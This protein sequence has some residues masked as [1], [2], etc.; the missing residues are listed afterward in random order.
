[1]PLRDL[2]ESTVLAL[3]ECVQAVSESFPQPVTVP[4]SNSFV[5]RYRNET[6]LLLMFLKAVKIA[7]NNSAAI[8]LIR[9]GFVQ[10]TYALCRMIDE[11]CEDIMFMAM[12]LGENGQASEDQRRFFRE[13]F[14][15]ELDNP[16]DPFSSTKRDRVPRRRIHAALSRMREAQTQNPSLDQAVSRALHQ[17]FSG[18]VHGPYF[19]LMELF[20]GSEHRFHTRGL[21]GTPRIEECERNQVNY[22]YRSL[23]AVQAVAFLANR[24]DV[25]SRL[26]ALA[27]EL[28][29][30][31]VCDVR[32]V[33]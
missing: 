18:F 15:E 31:T 17:T 29:T 27:V 3:D 4:R 8:A 14:Q 30:Q 25:V 2:L 6:I 10:E 1:M 9:A 12:P 11:S 7:S 23:V 21:L 26:E 24:P 19:H 13:F 20:G 5:F 32:K 22:V 28:A 16:T 33:K